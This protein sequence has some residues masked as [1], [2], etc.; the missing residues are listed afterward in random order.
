MSGHSLTIVSLGFIFGALVAS[1]FDVTGDTGEGKTERRHVADLETSP[2]ENRVSPPAPSVPEY[3]VVASKDLSMPGVRRLE[4][5]IQ[6]PRHYSVGDVTLIAKEIASTECRRQPLNALGIF[7]YGP[8]AHT[9]GPFDVARI[10]WAPNGLWEKARSVNS[11]DYSSFDY[12][13][14]YLEPRPEKRP[15]LSFSGQLGLLGTPLPNGAVLR[16]S[17]PGDRIA[18]RDPTELY[19][20]SASVDELEAFFNEAMSKAGWSRDGHPT[21]LGRCFTLYYRKGALMIGVSMNVNPETGGFM[22]MGS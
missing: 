9:D 8:G 14:T 15:T 11:G 18:N 10:D 13:V 17:T 19:S 7:F 6:L 12:N 4:K 3:T 1:Q 2:T 21:L 20:C 16:K 22:L 5:R